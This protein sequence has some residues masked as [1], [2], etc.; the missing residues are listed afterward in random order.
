MPFIFVHVGKAAGGSIRELI[1]RSS[2]DFNV[3]N[4]RRDGLSYD[5]D[6][7]KAYLCNSG[8]RQMDLSWAKHFEGTF[9]CPATTPLGGAIACPQPP[10]KCTLGCELDSHTCRQIYMGHNGLGTE[11]HWLPAPYLAKWWSSIGGQRDGNNLTDAWATLLPGNVAWCDTLRKA[12]PVSAQEYNMLYNE[13]SVPLAQSMDTLAS[14]WWR[15]F[16]R[17]A[18]WA[19]LYASLPVLRV[20]VI[21]EP[22]SWF[23]S[24]HLWHSRPCDDFSSTELFANGLAGSLCGVHCFIRWQADKTGEEEEACWMLAE[25]N[26][27]N[28]FAVVGLWHELNIFLDMVTA[29][30]GYINMSQ[31]LTSVPPHFKHATSKQKQ[32]ACTGILMNRSATYVNS[33]RSVRGSVRLYEV[34]VEVNRAQQRELRMCSRWPQRPP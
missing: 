26:L 8:H 33:S 31:A 14:T 29:R 18:S 19:S 5:V 27:R 9:R 4:E 12:R 22:F 6:G 15:D 2:V 10:S 30:V 13:C 3:S 21:R 7:T 16:G 24:K 20:V 25:D 28:S 17:G 1:A 23:V 34:A 32:V 11:L